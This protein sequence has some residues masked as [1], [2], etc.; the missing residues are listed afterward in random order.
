MITQGHHDMSLLRRIADYDRET[1]WRGYYFRA[2]ILL[3]LVH[4][5]AAGTLSAG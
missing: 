2:S 3:P 5:R 4:G 1:S